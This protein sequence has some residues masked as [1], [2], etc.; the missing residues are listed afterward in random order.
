MKDFKRLLG[1]LRPNWHIFLL[2]LISMVLVAV[3]ETATGALI[4]PITDVVFGTNVGARTQTLFNLQEF[5]PQDDWLKQWF[6]ISLMLI[7]FTILGGIAEY[8]SVYLMAKVG[9]SAVLQLR[10]ELYEHLLKQSSSFFEKHR[11]N[12]LV[13]KLVVSAT[14][15]ELA[16]SANLRD[17]LKESFALIFFVSAA[18]YYNWRLMLGALIIA[19]IIAYITSKF[20][21]TLRKLSEEAFEGNKL[22]TD[23]AQETLSNHQIVKAYRAEERE[24]QRFAKVA[25][26]IAQANLRSGKISAF[27]PP[28]ISLIGV[29][30]I[31]VLL[32][33]GLREINLGRMEAS[34][35]F[36]FL[37]FLFRSYD[38][39][40]K[41][42]RQHNELN[43]A[44][45]ATRDIWNILDHSETLPEKED[46]VELK[47]LQDKIEL[48]DVSFSYKPHGKKVLDRVSLEIP[49]GKIIALVG[50]SGGGKSSLTKLIQRLYD[51][52]EGAIFWDGIDL[53]NARLSSLRRQIA[54]VTQETVLFNDTIR[55]NISYGKP[56]ATDEEIERAARIAYAHDFIVALPQG[57]DT[58]VGERGQ[59]L[60][61]GQK[62]RIAIARAVLMDAPVLILDEATSALDAESENLV[63]RALANLLEGK[64]AIIIAHRLSTIRRADLIVVMEKG[65]IVEVG[66]HEELIAKRGIYKRLYE[67]Q[68]AEPFK[69]TTSRT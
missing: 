60:S 63:Q 69:K 67:L 7:T 48:K 13:S 25:L 35:F 42:S 62:Q 49:K 47:P 39:V 9:Q 37:F 28:T 11:T 5:I 56:D 27:S 6:A 18:F 14:A 20:S 43:K 58:I 57:Y 55:Y 68:F 12:F 50:E 24:K 4:V 51:P 36:T 8:F 32:F 30:L 16:V 38:P 22:L 54:L 45:A 17:V 59:F 29:L 53:R 23:T 46:A 33:F 52:T 44:F 40:R 1:Y 15:I 19:P 34:Q 21:K 41:I 10:R 66:T 61:G 3:F 26:K 64:T 31:S 2:A 65:K